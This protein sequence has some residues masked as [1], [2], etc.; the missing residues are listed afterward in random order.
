MNPFYDYGIE[1]TLPIIPI[2]MLIS[3]L[4]N[5]AYQN[6]Y[7]DFDNHL[8]LF[9]VKKYLSFCNSVK[10]LYQDSLDSYIIHQIKEIM[11]K[12]HRFPKEFIENYLKKFYFCQTNDYFL[13]HDNQVIRFLEKEERKNNSYIPPEYVDTLFDKIINIEALENEAFLLYEKAKQN[14]ITEEEF[15]HLACLCLD[16]YIPI[17]KNGIDIIDFLNQCILNNSFQINISLYQK[18]IRFYTLQIAKSYNL[19]LE[20]SFDELTYKDTI[21]GQFVENIGVI[22]YNPYKFYSEDFIRNLETV[23]HETD[24]ADALKNTLFP[25]YD[26]ILYQK[27]CLLRE[28]LGENYYRENYN[29]ISYERD[30]R[31]RAKKMVWHYLERISPLKNR[32]SIENLKEQIGEEIK[33]KT[34]QRIYKGKRKSVDIFVKELLEQ[35][36]LKNIDDFYIPFLEKEY[37]INGTRKSIFEIFAQKR[38]VQQQL[39][40]LYHQKHIDF[41]E[42]RKKES[43]LNIYNG[44]LYQA[45]YTKEELLFAITSFCN[46]QF[47]PHTT[48]EINQKLLPHL[49]YQF[50]KKGFLINPFELQSILLKYFLMIRIQNS[51]EHLK[52]DSGLDYCYVRYNDYVKK[53]KYFME[54]QYREEYHSIKR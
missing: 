14:K 21:Q 2:P 32:I 41:N 39:E 44:L 37:N 17:L 6:A 33:N 35:K 20:V 16:Y 1:D 7:F 3:I 54:Q 10:E 53:M 42:I 19:P 4:T 38:K 47:D 23:H 24:H 29:N 40:M 51:K 50:N 9:E 15:H 28:Y 12:E 45:D 31:I 8:D 46:Y 5:K 43:D 52:V 25:T 34:N 13:W 26:N 49:L 11:K 27:D 30:A 18:L 48:L 36:G 22:R